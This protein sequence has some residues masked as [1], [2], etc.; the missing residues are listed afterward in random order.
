MNNISIQ[1]AFEKLPSAFQPEQA[2]GISAVVQFLISG[3]GG[4][5]WGVTIKDGTCN[6][7]AGK[8]TAP[9]LTVAAD[10]SL[11]PEL[12]SGKQNGVMAFMQGKL[13]IQGDVSLAQ[14]LLG[15]FSIK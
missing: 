14:K 6:V 2:K 15:L 13:R 11:F 12:I 7:V 9:T 10:A 8:V 4:G 5:E 1:D 3:Q